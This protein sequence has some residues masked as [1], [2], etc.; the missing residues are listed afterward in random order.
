MG[1]PVPELPGTKR[2]NSNA[3]KEFGRILS[4]ALSTQVRLANLSGE[5]RFDSLRQALGNELDE[6]IDHLTTP[7]CH[8]RQGQFLQADWIDQVYQGQREVGGCLRS[9]GGA[10][11][12]RTDEFASLFNHASQGGSDDCIEGFD[13]FPRGHDCRWIL[14]ALLLACFSDDYPENE[15]FVRKCLSHGD[16]L[17]LRD[18][19]ASLPP[20][21]ADVG[22]SRKPAEGFPKTPQA[23]FH[24]R[25]KDSLC[26]DLL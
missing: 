9:S 16:E 5:D 1:R 13:P 21:E 15:D 6:K 10:G 26:P 14:S 24:N 23:G 19:L 3:K 12:V 18:R 25:P 8:G 22:A 4:E 11:P 7:L 17:V 20:V 2:S